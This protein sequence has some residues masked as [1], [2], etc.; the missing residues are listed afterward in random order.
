MLLHSKKKSSRTE[1]IVFL[2]HTNELQQT[3]VWIIKLFDIYVFILRL[4]HFFVI[5]LCSFECFCPCFLVTYYLV[6][7]KEGVCS[8]AHHKWANFPSCLHGSHGIKLWLVLG[9]QHPGYSRQS[10]SLNV[11]S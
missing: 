4:N 5:G 3:C 2:K 7:G 9:I 6:E 10:D 8:K 1:L 11:C